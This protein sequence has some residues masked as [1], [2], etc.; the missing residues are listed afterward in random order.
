[1]KKNKSVT[2]TAPKTAILPKKSTVSSSAKRF[3]KRPS[4]EDVFDKRDHS[5]SLP[6]RNS[7]H[8]IELDDDEND[9]PIPAMDIDDEE[10]ERDDCEEAEEDDEAE[11][12]I[13]YLFAKNKI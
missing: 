10:E 11:L 3:K 1:V 6:P 9:L 12:G 5:P 7:R 2:A 4:V 13:F 8:I